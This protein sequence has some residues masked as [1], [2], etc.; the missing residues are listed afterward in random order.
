MSYSIQRAVPAQV[1]A[2]CAIERDAM[3]LFRGHR[4]W[5]FYAPVTM[6]PELLRPEL[7]GA[8]PANRPRAST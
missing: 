6:P 5:R 1:E 3:E 4:A 8:K 7:N 2:L